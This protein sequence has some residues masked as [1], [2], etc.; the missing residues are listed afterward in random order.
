MPKFIQSRRV[1]DFMVTAHSH[2][3]CVWYRVIIYGGGLFH[4]LKEEVRK[5]K[6]RSI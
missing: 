3:G 2:E 6:K 1:R 5:G 4:E